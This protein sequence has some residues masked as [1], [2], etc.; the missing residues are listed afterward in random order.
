ML[1]EISE[2]EFYTIFTST[3]NPFLTKEFY[4]LNKEKVEEVKFLIIDEPK[5]CIGM[6]L[7]C[8]DHSLLSPYSAPFGGVHFS[9]SNIYI[10]KIE[11]FAENL[12]YKIKR[13]STS[14][15]LFFIYLA[16]TLSANFFP[17]LNFTTF[18]AAILIS[19][20]VCGFLPFLAAL[21]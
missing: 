7:G 19:F 12:S 13:L 10:D 4:T 20:P 5:P 11:T 15:N 9:H 8:V 21:F 17:T 14:D 16:A 2:K 3:Q 1:K 6:V 18:L